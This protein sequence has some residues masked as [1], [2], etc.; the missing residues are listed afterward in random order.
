[1]KRISALALAIA[2]VASSCSFVQRTDDPKQDAV[3]TA[4]CVMMDDKLSIAINDPE[5]ARTYLN[6]LVDRLKISEPEAVRE[7]ADLLARGLE[8][9]PR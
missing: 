2:M 9:I 6:D 3:E 7:A 1:M 4:I 8:C 5:Y